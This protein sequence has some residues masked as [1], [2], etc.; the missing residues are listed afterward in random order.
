[1]SFFGSKAEIEAHFAAV[2]ATSLYRKIMRP[3]AADLAA[4]DEQAQLVKERN[5]RMRKPSLRSVMAQAKR[6]GVTASFTQNVDG[7]ITVTLGAPTRVGGSSV[8]VHHVEDTPADQV[9]PWDEVL[10]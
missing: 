8:D 10:H 3:S 2:E 1:M 4:E 5:R 7:S 6:A 9:N